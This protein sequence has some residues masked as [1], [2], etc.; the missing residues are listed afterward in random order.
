MRKLVLL[1]LLLPYSARS[2]ATYFNIQFDYSG[3]WNASASILETDSFFIASGGYVSPSTLDTAY[4]LKINKNG[5]TISLWKADF[6]PSGKIFDI[7]TSKNQN[8]IE[9]RGRMNSNGLDDI[10]NSDLYIALLSLPMFDTLKIKTYGLP[11]YGDYSHSL[12]LKT[13]D[14]GFAVTG[15]RFSPNIPGQKLILLKCD[16]LLNQVFLKAYSKNNSDNHTGQGAIE[17][18]DKGFI[19]VGSRSFNI[20][21]LQGTYLKV[22]SLG[23]LLWWK[24]IVPQGDEEFIILDHIEP[25]IDGNYLVVG[26]KSVFT[27]GFPQYMVHLILKINGQGDVI[28]TKEHGNHVYD[29][30]WWRGLSP[31]ED[32]NFL[33]YGL[34]REHETYPN[35]KEYGTISKITPDGEVLWERRYSASS[36]GKLYDVFWK[37][38][39]TTDGGIIACGSTWG[40]SLTRENSWIVKLDSLGCLEPGCDSISTGVV[41]LPVGENS[42]IKIYPNPTGGQ[43]TVEAQK[44]NVIKAVKI[45]DL[46]GRRIVNEEYGLGRASLSVDLGGEP[47]GVYFCTALVGGVWVTRQ[48]ILK[49]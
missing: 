49:K 31:L 20:Y 22:D 16:S 24:D 46:Q 7:T 36:E 44:G 35:M 26:R 13:M 42:P 5:E 34:D 41:E 11:N 17:T 6:F 25:L 10:I 29:D 12:T 14:N 37:A 30:T 43:L 4:L 1:L 15:Y 28:W 38:I 21:D 32:G 47:P 45:Y 8:T 23:N 3:I 33:G 27:P 9:I 18:P 39:P 19:V 2:Q 48:F 40:D